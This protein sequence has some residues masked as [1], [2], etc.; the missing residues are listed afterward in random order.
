MSSDEQ[1]SEASS[2]SR[3]PSS[4]SNAGEP[5]EENVSDTSSEFNAKASSDELASD[6]EVLRSWY[7]FAADQSGFIGE[8]LRLLRER[9]GTTAEQQRREFGASD[10]AFEQ[11]RGMI[12]PRPDRL[13]ADAHAIAVYCGIA[14]PFAF[15]QAL[16]LATKIRGPAASLPASERYRAA[17]EAGDDLDDLSNEDA[18]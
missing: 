9:Q 2:K 11:V 6:E 13:A 3:V 1:S 16:L 7:R 18:T 12:M 10:E 14:N 8:S 15:V 5:R 17:L 4:D